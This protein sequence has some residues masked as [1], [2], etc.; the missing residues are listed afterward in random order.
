LHLFFPEKFQRD[1]ERQSER[2]AEK[3]QW[4]RKERERERERE[5]GHTTDWSCQAGS[6]NEASENMLTCQLGF[7][8][9]VGFLSGFF[10]FFF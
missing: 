2:G 5:W 7:A 10:F 8:S 1:S 6:R 4:Q 3:E 9:E